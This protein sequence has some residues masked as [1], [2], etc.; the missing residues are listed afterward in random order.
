MDKFLLSLITEWRKLGLPFEHDTVVVGVSG[1]ADS[2][3]LLIGL[4]DLR[5]RGKLEIRIVAA[6]FN[7]RLRGGSSDADE[8]FV[9]SI[10][11]ERRLELAIGRQVHESAG[12]V[13]QNARKARY[14]FLKNTAENTKAGWVLTAHTMNDQAETFLMNLLRGSG[15][16]GLSG[17]RPVRELDP[18]GEGSATAGSDRPDQA[19]GPTDAPSLPFTPILLA[20]PLLRWARRADTENFVRSFGLEY[21]YDTMNDDMSFKRVRVR[22][23][24][25][26]LMKEFNPKIV[27][28]LTRTAEIMQQHTD[29][30][31][32]LQAEKA[33]AGP[34]PSLGA[35]P[36]RD[37]RALDP[38]KL[39]ELL[40]SWLRERRGSLRSI[41][42]RH[43]DSMARL[44]QSKKS[45]NSVELPGS[46]R[47]RKRA[48]KLFFEN[49]KVDK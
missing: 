45:G 6:H 20:R 11:E 41:S 48:G 42:A 1:G 33:R 29:E 38:A 39:P 37:L 43:I 46:G 9:R 22:K 24:L 19:G 18:I 44:V 2:L 12:N 15:I 47:V 3:S 26:P 34:S 17:M 4:D 16:S 36:V 28:T 13:E 23:M 5:K 35:L 32:A 27:E 10:A 25:L 31:E 7:H 30:A 8:E 40:R 14:R 21:R 49:I